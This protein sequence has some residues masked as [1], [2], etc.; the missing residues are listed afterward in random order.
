MMADTS[1]NNGGV[2]AGSPSVVGGGSGGALDP[3]VIPQWKK[4][5]IQ[6]RKNLA[7]TI[8]AV[9]TQVHDSAS[10]VAAAISAS[11]SSPVLAHPRTP[12]GG[13][14]VGSPFYAGTKAAAAAAAAVTSPTTA[15]GSFMGVHFAAN[16]HLQQQ[17]HQHQQQARGV[18]SSSVGVLRA[19][20]AVAV[21][22][23]PSSSASGSSP[24]SVPTA[25][26]AHSH[27]NAGSE[28]SGSSAAI[29]TNRTGSSGTN[30]SVIAERESSSTVC[31]SG[32]PGTH[33][34]SGIG[35]GSSSSS[36]SVKSLVSGAN[37]SA[38]QQ[39]QHGNA[40]EGGVAARKMVAATAAEEIVVVY[41]KSSVLGGLADAT[42]GGG[43]GI[44]GGGVGAG[45]ITAIG[46]AGE[47][48]KYGP[49]IVSRLRCRYLSLALRQSVAKQR[50]SLNSMRRATSLNNLLDEESEDLS[51]REQS[52]GSEGTGQGGG[53][54]QQ[55]QQQ[56]KKYQSQNYHYQHHQQQQQQHREQYANENGN[57][58]NHNHQQQQLHPTVVL[59]PPYQ[60]QPQHHFAPKQQPWIQQQQQLHKEEE[61]GGA[62]KVAPFLR[63]VQNSYTRASRQV[64]KKNEYNRYT[65]H[66]RGAGGA[67]AVLLKRAR[68]V[69]ALVRYDHKAWER[70]GVS[71]VV[72]PAAAAAAV[73][74]TAAAAA[75]A[76]APTPAALAVSPTA[77]VGSNVIILDEIAQAPTTAQATVLPAGGGSEG[78]ATTN[79]ISSSVS[80]TATMLMNGGKGGAAGGGTAATP[81]ELPLLVSDCVTIEEKI[82]NGREKGDPKPKRLTSI[83]DA[84]ERPPPDVVKQTMKI[85]EANANRRGGRGVNGST[86]GGSDVATKVASYRSIIISGSATAGA[87]TAAAAV[88]PGEKP[89]ITHPKP[90]LSPKKPNIMPRTASPKQQQQQQP[91]QVT[92]AKPPP[93]PKSLEAVNN[94]KNAPATA[95][96]IVAVKNNNKAPIGG[97]GGGATS[98]STPPSPPARSKHTAAALNGVGI[99]VAVSKNMQS[100][101]GDDDDGTQSADPTADAK[102]TNALK[103]G[104]G[105]VRDH[106]QHH[107]SNSSSSS[108]GTTQTAAAVTPSAKQSAPG[109]DGGNGGSGH[110][111]KHNGNTALEAAAVPSAASSPT[112]GICDSPSIQQLTTKLGSLHLATSTPTGAANGSAVSVQDRRNL[113]YVTSD[114]EEDD[115]EDGE[116]GKGDNVDGENERG[117]R[118]NSS[119]SY[120]VN[121]ESS[122]SE[123]AR[124][125]AA[126]GGSEN[127]ADD[128]EEAELDDD[129]ER[130]VRKISRTA[131]ENIARAGTTTQ[132]RFNGAVKSYLPGGAMGKPAAPAPST[133]A[134]A[135]PIPM[136]R[137]SLA[138]KANGASTAA[139]VQAI[140]VSG[141]LPPEGAANNSVNGVGGGGSAK[142][143]SSGSTG[144]L[145]QQGGV[146]SVGSSTAPSPP[147]LT[148]REIE[149]NQINRE[150]S[151]EPAVPAAA[152]SSG[153]NS[154]N[155]SVASGG[156]VQVASANNNNNNANNANS[157]GASGGGAKQT[158]AVDS[159][160]SFVAKWGTGGVVGTGVAA[161]ATAGQSSPLAGLV[162]VRK[163][164]KPPPSHQQEG[165]N[166]MVFN[167]SDR[168]DVPDYIE[169][170]GVIIRPRPRELPKP[171]E[172]G[173]VVLGDL[174]L[175][176]STDPDDAWAAGP[177]SPCN[178]EFAN[179]YIV[180]NGKSS[181]RNKTSRSNNKFKIQFDDS[182][183]STYEYPSE[184]SLLEETNGFDGVDNGT[185][186]NGASAFADNGLLS[187]T[188]KLLSSVPLGS[189]PFASYTPVKAAIDTTFELGVTRTPSPSAASTA[190]STGSN[191]S[192]TSASN[193]SSNSHHSATSAS[194]SGISEKQH[195]PHTV[196]NGH[197][198]PVDRSNS[199]GLHSSNGHSGSPDGGATLLLNGATGAAD[200]DALFNGATGEPESIQY[201]KPASDEQTV[202]W[203]QG[204][205]VTDLLF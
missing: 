118:S 173:F 44:G 30:S 54:H 76:A 136:S 144:A 60:K 97:G 178:G 161:V 191:G 82:I 149:K 23:Q 171:G 92:A 162:P 134:P 112:T 137:E 80:P 113:E 31:S 22:V 51:E 83:I 188:N 62:V 88:G 119:R 168:K 146:G 72:G 67:D 75:V 79:G 203:S 109:S 150:K 123:D 81:T 157:S 94:L 45:G 163:K 167:F 117:R 90:P 159:T 130:S 7:K 36:T 139:A 86:N 166:T 193:H 61:G 21:V 185:D 66:H 47:E 194:S 19:S 43:G 184:T 186:T 141:R 18:G 20:E 78:H 28:H 133:K 2:A 56:Q 138:G 192:L 89:P 4:E 93:T 124:D 84:D 65:K 55:Q 153:T 143:H 16:E 128:D 200:G 126:S 132:F 8:G 115:D 14:P 69:E 102:T 129:E 52:I 108:N 172:S 40:R 140:E 116:E 13:F 152:A 165:T 85:F 160:T 6:R 71:P 169:N 106:H 26:G 156:G 131:M 202:N 58:H 189:A 175:E 68:S 164:T 158:S 39:Q 101:G 32:G 74:T 120:Q 201:L 33:T 177:P 105:T 107:D 49:G 99:G 121:P 37:G 91:H 103:N 17:H 195:L 5:L 181:M 205:R 183:T 174:T 73:T 24:T 9:A 70:D 59:Q 96:P 25:N 204:T 176:T 57:N 104:V 87:T 63:G 110:Q 199:N 147:S 151:G 187:H 196:P 100:N 53:P 46:D 180:I 42:G 11:G 182:L 41:E 114:E 64:E 38:Q 15:P 155:G 77:E 197:H 198:H 125:G 190:S 179:A 27:S 135:P 34:T 154:I 35:S 48:L 145:L 148:R 127:D 142:Q 3:N 29:A 12:T 111:H 10:T 95:A 122:E 1:T 50:P 170:D 98:E